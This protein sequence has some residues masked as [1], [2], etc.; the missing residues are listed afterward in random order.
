MADYQAVALGIKPQDP[1]QAFE[2]INSILGMQQ[3]R[4]GLQIQAQEL[5]QQELKTQQ[6]QGL[7]QFF[8]QWD[9]TEHLS[10]D[11]TTDTESVHNSA[12]YKMAGNAKPLIDQQLIQIKSGQLQNKQ[13]LTSLNTDVLT[14]YA[15]NMGALADDPDVQKGNIDGQAKIKAHL[16]Q[17]SQLSPDAARVA[18]IFGPVLARA[19]PDRLQHLVQ[20]QQ[21]LGADVL[22][23]RG[24]QNPQQTTNAAGQILN[25]EVG[26]G[27]LSAPPQGGAN[28]NPA[29]PAVAAAT[30]TAA[31][32]AEDDNKR[33]DQI[34]ASVAPSRASVTL[35]DQV[36]KLADEV[37]TGKFSK[38]V[39]DY[40][41]T[42]GQ[43][44]DAIAARQLLSKYSAQLKTQGISNAPTDSAR[45]QIE[46]GLPDPDTMSPE[47]IKGAAEYIKG[48]MLM[49][50]SRAANARKFQ[51][52]HGSTQGLRTADDQL[53]SS[54][55]ALMY[56]YHNLPKGPARTEF[57]QR[58]FSN[59]QDKNDFIRR[60]N[61]VEHYGG[62]EQ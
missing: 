53:T 16:S 46:A 13:A 24:Q 18:G 32:T 51:A 12:A 62:F 47:A 31:G 34:S 7:Q 8:K 61:A 15:K 49:N 22:G 21:M 29:S 55:D 28:L 1:N 10:D 6:Q 57:I 58:H 40:A 36:S 38:V 43:K 35:A 26:T 9:P 45:S 42:I 56:T 30:R 5:Q 17:F 50:L 59:A 19:P 14:Q 52:T 11:G 39:T 4:Q 20:S 48:S 23:Q 27:A 54:A 2:S 3:K 33:N 44:D 60:K 41:A 37:R 25:R